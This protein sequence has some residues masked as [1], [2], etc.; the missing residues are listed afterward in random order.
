MFNSREYIAP[1]GSNIGR[2]IDSTALYGALS[3]SLRIFVSIASW[4]QIFE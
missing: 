4:Q 3:P 2:K 1:E